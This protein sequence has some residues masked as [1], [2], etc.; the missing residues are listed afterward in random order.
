[1]I[2][3]IGESRRRRLARITL[4]PGRFQEGISDI[5]ELK[6]IALHKAAQ[7]KALPGFTAHSAPQ[8]KAVLAIA[9]HLT[10]L[11]IVGGCLQIVDFPITDIFQKARLIEQLE[12]KQIV[13]PGLKLVEDQ[14]FGFQND[15]R[16][17]FPI[18]PRG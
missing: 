14:T 13:P 1:M 2:S 9:L 18:A 16:H 15:G 4:C 6:A 5:G 3:G 11:N 12:N 8:T 17:G 10:G 7:P